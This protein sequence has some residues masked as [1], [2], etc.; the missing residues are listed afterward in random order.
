[1]KNKEQDD[2]LEQL[3]QLLHCA[4]AGVL[5]E[6]LAAQVEELIMDCWDRFEGSSAEGTTVEK[7]SDRMENL[8]WQPP[9]VRFEIERH[10][11][12]CCGSSR[13]E[14]HR[15]SVNLETGHARCGPGGFRQLRPR[16][17]ALDSNQIAK[18]VKAVVQA[19]RLNKQRS[20]KLKWFSSD[21]VQVIVGKLIPA[22]CPQQTLAG[23]RRR[24]RDLLTKRLAEIG[25]TKVPSTAPNTYQKAPPDA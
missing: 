2:E 17:P 11:A 16:N 14:I 20:T 24:F 3:R 19:I 8:N 9:D 7:L 1:M 4:P 5:A 6:G 18:I 23:R 25:W 13:A 12:F 10:G 22:N 21:K 15:W